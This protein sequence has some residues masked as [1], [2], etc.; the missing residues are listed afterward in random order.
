MR[1]IQFLMREAPSGVVAFV[2]LGVLGLHSSPAIAVSSATPATSSVSVRVVAAERTTPTGP[3]WAAS[4]AEVHGRLAW[5]KVDI[6]AEDAR[7]SVLRREFARAIGVNL[8]D[9][10]PAVQPE[11]DPGVSLSL[12]DITASEALEIIIDATSGLARGT[13]QVREGILEMGPKQVLAARTAAVVRTIDV[14]DLLLEPPYF[15]PDVQAVGLL[16]GGAGEDP[17]QRTRRLTPRQIGAELVE[18]IVQAVEPEAWQPLTDA[19]RADGLRDPIDPRDPWQGRNLDPLRRDPGSGHEVPIYVQ[20]R[21]ATIRLKEK[22]LVVRAP[23]FVIRGIE[24]LPTPVPPP[25]SLVS[26]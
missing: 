2:V 20:G 26:P 11:L 12:R 16:R 15:V 1:L 24:G 21:W 6:D 13:W 8:V 14:T 17:S 19:E 4:D 5:L 23:A 18:S 9:H 3:R 25:A 22:A 7:P 10:F